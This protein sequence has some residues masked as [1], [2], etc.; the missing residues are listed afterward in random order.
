MR[1]LTHAVCLAFFLC[2]LLTTQAEVL[3]CATGS[4]FTDGQLFTVDP[5]TGVATLVGDITDSNGPI[6]ITGL[7]FN[8]NNGVL[9]G[10]TGN[11]SPNDLRSLV[12]IDT[13]TGQATLIGS[14]GGAPAT[15]ISFD[16]SGVLYGWLGGSVNKL[17]TISLSTGAATVVG[18]PGPGAGATQGG[19]LSFN[20]PGTLYLCRE[21]DSTGDSQL[22]TVDQSTGQLTSGPTLSGVVAFTKMNAMAFNASGSLYSVNTDVGLSQLVT[23][24]T[25]TGAVS[26]IGALP[27]NTDGLAFAPVVVRFIFYNQSAFDGNDA[28][29]NA[30]DD[31]AIATD[32][33]ALLPGQTATFANYTSYS[34]GINGV[35]VDIA[36]LPGT[37]A[38]GDFDFKVGNDN[39]P[40]GWG[41]ATAP[42]S[43]SVRSG[44]GVNGSDRVTLIWANNA[45]QK[46]WLQITVK[47]TAATGLAA[48]DVFYFGN[49]IGEAG[50]SATD[51]KVDPADE[52]L[53]RSHPRNVLNPAP[54]DYFYDY[55]RDKRVD[56]ADQL[57]ARSNPTSIITALKLID[58]P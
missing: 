4:N 16:S 8:P 55:N 10:V 56:P 6:G 34:R 36:G 50:N 52:L 14:L 57:I 20:P 47:A 33:T 42:T 5:A 19:A 17:A 29:A 43:I 44:E 49:A 54:I 58:L 12:T 46:K 2:S 18:P 7:A 35:M 41:A 13:S 22:S 39:T 32:K 23:I 27:D 51:A 9:Y 1:V 25:A 28:S 21:D 31:G 24:D 26:S 45:I 30:S 37:P 15:D 11:N 48:D 3:Y 53:A 38:A 40:S